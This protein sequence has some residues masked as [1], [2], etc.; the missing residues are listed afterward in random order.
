MTHL[1]VLL[2]DDHAI[3]REG[4]RYLLSQ[5]PEI[6]VVGE[7]ANS[8][9]AYKKF[10]E[11]APD[12][13]I[14]D[15]SMPGLGGVELIRRVSHWQTTRT[16]VFTMHQNPSFALQAFRAGAA[17]YVT[18]SSPPDVLVNA[19]YDVGANRMALSPDIAHALAIKKLAEDEQLLD[20]LS[21]REFEILKMLCER[22]PHQQ[23]AEALR[24]S[25][26]TVSNAHYMIKRKLG[27]S[28]DMELMWLAIQ[29]NVVEIESQNA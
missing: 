8:D 14:V 26:K 19:I 4:Y 10:Q 5:K 20:E 9:D 21:T 28:S 22:M 24:I 25:V 29:L 11:M 3:V 27:V 1:R 16:L 13:M 7:A 2:A 6:E 23:I 18:K 15:I 17:G 12:L